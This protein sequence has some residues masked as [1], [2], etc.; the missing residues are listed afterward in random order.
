MNYINLTPHTVVVEYGESETIHFEPSGSVA[1]VEMELKEV[2]TDGKI[3]IFRK[4]IKGV[5]GIPEPEPETRYIVS[6]MV[7]DATDRKD[8]V[9]PNTNNA[10]RNEKG[11]IISVPGFITK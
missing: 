5:T 4:E 8:V 9:A 7:F 3:K 10:T 2:S 11:F 1:R 6:S